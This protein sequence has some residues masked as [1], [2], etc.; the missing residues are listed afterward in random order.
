MS[1][2]TE[3]A[4]SNAW[5]LARERGLPGVLRRCRN[6]GMSWQQ[7]EGVLV[8]CDGK[9]NPWQYANKMIAVWRAER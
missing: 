7:T 8:E 1:L 5:A 4:E 2:L 6:A 9:R 3:Q